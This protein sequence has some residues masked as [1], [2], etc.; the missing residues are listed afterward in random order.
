MLCHTL[1]NVKGKTVSDASARNK[2]KSSKYGEDSILQKS[3]LLFFFQ[4]FQ[5]Y[6]LGSLVYLNARRESVLSLLSQKKLFE[7]E[8]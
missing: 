3:D 6:L 2:V 4:F 7:N 5:L 1:K 8:L